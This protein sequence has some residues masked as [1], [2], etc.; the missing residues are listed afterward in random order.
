MPNL[1]NF[2]SV[3]I[4]VLLSAQAQFV[5]LPQEVPLETWSPRMGDR[6]IIDT[7][8]NEG[9]VVHPATHEYVRFP[10]I[11]GQRRVVNYIGLTYN[12]ATPNR[13]WLIQSLDT[14]SDRYTYGPEGHFLRLY[15]DGERTHYGIHGHAAEDI[16]FDRDNRFQSMGCIIVQT[17]ILDMLMKTFALNEGV[18]AVSTRYGLE[19][20]EE[21]HRE[22]IIAQNI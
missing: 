6:I 2:L 14:Q 15:V 11:T 1:S 12:A 4:G 5:V 3:V 13:E 20:I 17:D 19:G 9:Y 10:L 7:Q 22:H 16:M 18:I 21:V 8:K